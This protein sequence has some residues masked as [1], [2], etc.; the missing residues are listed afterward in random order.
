MAKASQQ[1]LGA[2][3]VHPVVGLATTPMAPLRVDSLDAPSSA[4]MVSL[5]DLHVNSSTPALKRNRQAGITGH[6]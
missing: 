1:A 2:A 4:K 3:L 5:A 6:R